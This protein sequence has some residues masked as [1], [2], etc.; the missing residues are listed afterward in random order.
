MSSTSGSSPR[1]EHART[2]ALHRIAT[3]AGRLL[4]APV[5]AV[6]ACEPPRL[7]LRTSFGPAHRLEQD[8]RVL[9]WE[10]HPALTPEKAARL[11]PDARA[12]T[13][14]A[15]RVTSVRFCLAVLIQGPDGSPAGML[16]AADTQART[17]SESQMN[18]IL[19]LGTLAGN[20]FEFDR[21]KNQDRSIER[22]KT[23]E[24][25]LEK[26]LELAKF[27][28]D[29]RQLHRLSTT[30][31]ESLEELFTDYLETGRTIFG[32]S[33][34]V[35]SQVR[36][37]Y[38][39]VRAVRGDFPSP[40][41]GMTFELNRVH[42]GAVCEDRA[43]VAAA[44]VEDDARLAGRPHY[45]PSRQ[46]SYIGTPILVD[47]E[48]FGVLSF[49]SPN[50]R[51]RAYTAHEVEIVE[52]MAKSIGRSILEG[53]MQQARDRA[54]VLEHDRSHVLEM[55]AK[56][57]ALENVLRQIVHMIERQSPS[58]AGAILLVR[59]GKLDCE[60]APGM[61]ES[62]HRRMQGIPIPTAGGCCLSAAH[63]RRTA[64]FDHVGPT[65][66]K[67]EPWAAVHE[68]CWQACGAA[69]I[70]SGSG[71]LLGIL[72]VY[73][74]VA[75]QPRHVDAGL[76]EMAASLAAIAVEHR[77]LTDRL[78]YHAQHDILT[79]LP[80]RNLLTQTLEEKVDRARENGGI[81]GVLFID[82]DRFKQINDHLG[83][84]AGDTVLREVAGRIRSCL[85]SGEF[86]ARHGGDEFVAVLSHDGDESSVLDR[87]REILEALRSPILFPNH[88][89]PIYVT[90]SIGLS[91]FPHNGE[92]ADSLLG[93]ADLAMYQAKN[94]GRNDV[95][96]FAPGREGVRAARLA[97]EH[98]LRRAVEEGQ[99]HLGFQPIVD[100]RAAGGVSLDAFEVLLFWSHPT[101]GR[102]APSQF[103]P[104]AEECGLIGPIGTWVLRHACQR[105]ASLLRAGLPPVRLCVNVSAI[106]FA[107]PD[108]VGTVLA[109]LEESGMESRFLQLEFTESAIM[110]NVETA[111]PK[112]DRLRELG[113][114][115]ALDDFGTG[116]SSL[117]YLRWIP[118]DCLK[119]DQT[120]IAEISSSGGALTLVQTI[121]ALA[122]NMGLTVVAEGVESESQL[123]L[124]RGIECDKAQGHLFGVSLAA[125]EVE[126]WLTENASPS[127][128]AP[129]PP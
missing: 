78:A 90:A 101:M 22:R 15:A 113:V 106:Q 24:Q 40:R 110:E 26:S 91:I 103:I 66:P 41:A 108:F 88:S 7:F 27:S 97:M 48:I 82:L 105:H 17:I 32:L 57:Q 102:I 122:H 129:P 1:Q 95:C 38:A 109:A 127:A 112:L 46:A 60:T 29:L 96:S 54:E 86:A 6:F 85:R 43:T 18:H 59:G 12:D 14:L 11:I 52:L 119:I 61:P 75:I 68:F 67:N 83:H 50:S 8:L 42:C 123:E 118:V 94:N 3:L 98:S 23:Q 87:S 81:L 25:L 64:I 47:G 115:L 84:T 65:C 70:L 120:F 73:W 35:V 89:Q 79:G 69:P 100:I 51:R 76:L 99:L 10:L 58:L 128:G 80:N 13:R 20:E 36:G 4:E 116:Y 72:T 56:D 2:G 77:N 44:S 93:G 34:G 117:S 107:R 74:K 121:L 55:V 125:E 31:Y 92:T 104:V 49:S 114:R 53:R 28:E 21:R 45:G 124:L 71:D 63:T 126:H 62:F 39:A 9:A 111:M 30:N 16:L 5:V 37:R 19:D 33:Y